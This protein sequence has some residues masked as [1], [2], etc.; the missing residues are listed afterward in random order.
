MPA[1]MDAIEVRDVVG[2]EGVDL[3]DSVC[4]NYLSMSGADFL[5]QWKQGKSHLL[6]REKDSRISRVISTL[7]FA[8]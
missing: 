3:F 8:A 2:S 5:A 7:P 6:T 4:M 1:T